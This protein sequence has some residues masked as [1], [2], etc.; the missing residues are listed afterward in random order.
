ME[1]DDFKENL[2]KVGVEIG[3]VKKGIIIKTI[4]D[5]PG[6]SVI[7]IDEKKLEELY[8][9]YQNNNFIC[10]D[11]AMLSTKS[12]EI[13]IENLNLDE[14]I[15]KQ[16][17][18]YYLS[19][20]K[21]ENYYLKEPSI[22]YIINLLICFMKKIENE[23]ENVKN[24]LIEELK[25][26]I[27]INGLFYKK[28][29]NSMTFEEQLIFFL[30][31]VLLN[32]RLSLKIETQSEKENAEFED[33]FTSFSFEYMRLKNKGL[34]VS[35]DIYKIFGINR[36]KKNTDTLSYKEDIEVT[37]KYN[38][39]LVNFYTI[40]I[41]NEDPYIQYISYYHILEYH[42]NDIVK[43]TILDI[44][45]EPNYNLSINSQEEIANKIV[46]AVK[47]IVKRGSERELL[48]QVLKKYITDTQDIKKSIC[49]F[50]D[51][52]KNQEV[53]FS[54]GSKI[55]WDIDP[56][57]SDDILNDILKQISNRI[58]ETRNSLV[59][60]KKNESDDI[61][62]EF[63]KPWDNFHKEAL[64]QEIPLIKTIAEL[65]IQRT[66]FNLQ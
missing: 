15:T 4:G 22:E 62:D 33:L 5:Y 10:N 11:L 65:I 23:E 3:N 57:I 44:L 8:N 19:E 31:E 17:K 29:E 52:Y 9:K 54:K 45:K 49:N 28:K 59:H 24:E 66:S 55:N 47:R 26:K 27:Y 1:F 20:P 21:K 35:K 60:T 13:L 42:Y 41:E 39:K 43:L 36:K 61:N 56:N 7:S 6:E 46:I 50:C 58:Y 34:V 25:G 18:N 48:K 37:K 30:N 51:Y 63:Y 2:L 40:G 14:K 38:S 64:K 12:Y 53:C 32:N 16:E